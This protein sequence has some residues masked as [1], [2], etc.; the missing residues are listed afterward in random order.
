[1]VVGWHRDAV[2]R[3]VPQDGVCRL[4]T[5]R[6]LTLQTYDRH[7]IQLHASIAVGSELLNK[8]LEGLISFDLPP[9]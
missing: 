6:M 5:N 9:D 1:M 4:L 3:L 7:Q 8:M 2:G